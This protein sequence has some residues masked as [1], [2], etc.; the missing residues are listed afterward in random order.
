MGRIYVCIAAAI[1]LML[2]TLSTTQLLWAQQRAC[3]H[4][5]GETA[6]D[7]ARRQ[8]AIR[9]A[10]AINTAQSRTGAKYQP[11][12]ELPGLPG[13]PTGFGVHLAATAD[14][15][16]L[17]IKDAT[18]PCRY[19]LFSDHEGLIYIGAPLQ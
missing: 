16:L 9:L 14:G 11:L 3:L 13:V 1:A 10:R 2:G 17:S 19:T 7:A 15:Y 8:G 4:G 6:A 18:D 5:P 12:A